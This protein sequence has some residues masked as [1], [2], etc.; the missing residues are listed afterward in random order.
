M[1]TGLLH[2]DDGHVDDRRIG[3]AAL[4]LTAVGLSIAD[5]FGG[6]SAQSEIVT[7]LIYG[8]ALVLG[9]TVAE[10]FGKKMGA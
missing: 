2:D 4:L 10:K 9:S 1:N 8:G 3:G 6:L 5:L 7:G